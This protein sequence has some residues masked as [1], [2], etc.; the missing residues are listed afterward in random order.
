MRI[1]D[2]LENVQKYHFC[3]NPYLS[4]NLKFY[5]MFIMFTGSALHACYL[6]VNYGAKQ[7]NRNITA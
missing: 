2:L 1:S 5:P 4:T 7:Q 6:K 3:I